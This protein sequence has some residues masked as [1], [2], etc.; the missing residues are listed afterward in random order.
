MILSLRPADFPLLSRV[1][2]HFVESAPYA[3]CVVRMQALAFGL[4]LS[5]KLARDASLRWM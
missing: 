5:A 2:A 4:S 3:F 1:A